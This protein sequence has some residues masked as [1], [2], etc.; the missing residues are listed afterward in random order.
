MNLAAVQGSHRAMP[1]QG[2][3]GE[4]RLLPWGSQSGP[5]V[6]LPWAAGLGEAS[7]GSHLVPSLSI[8]QVTGD[9][10]AAL[11]LEEIRQEV[12]RANQDTN[13]AQRSKWAAVGAGVGGEGLGE[14]RR[15][16]LSG[17]LPSHLLLHFNLFGEAGQNENRAAVSTVGWIS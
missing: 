15:R 13:T 12:V 2:S 14:A 8:C 5:A 7:L 16:G 6:W 1:T 9:P 17:S 11:W 3:R 10:G 4:W